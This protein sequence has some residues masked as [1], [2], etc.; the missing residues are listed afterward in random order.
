MA[1]V[2]KA[3][4]KVSV[5]LGNRLD[6]PGANVVLLYDARARLAAGSKS[7]RGVAGPSA[8]GGWPYGASYQRK[9]D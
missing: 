4:A 3:P 8:P 7:D 9:A 5:N 2:V 6:P 1:P